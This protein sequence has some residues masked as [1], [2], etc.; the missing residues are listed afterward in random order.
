MAA[1]VAEDLV[2]LRRFGPTRRVRIDLH[3]ISLFGPAKQR[4]LIRWEWITSISPEDSGVV[5]SSDADTLVLPKGAYG[6]TPPDLAS[7]LQAARSIVE[8]PDIIGSLLNG[9]R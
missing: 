5:V 1:G 2:R 4:T 3:G 9:E 6:L 7:R 8:R